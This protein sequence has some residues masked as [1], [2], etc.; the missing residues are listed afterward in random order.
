MQSKKRRRW[1]KWILRFIIGVIVLFLAIL[2]IFDYFV[3]F[4]M[5]DKELH[6]FFKKHSVPAQVR[7][8]QTG[9]RTIRYAAIGNDSLPVLLFIHG[10][11]SSLSIYR[12]YYKDSLFLK[13]FRM[14]AVDRPGYGYSGLGKPEPSIQKQAA[15]IRPILDSLNQAK[16]PVIVMGGSYGT[17][18]ACRL[19]MDYP[20]LVNGLV[21][22]APSL[23]PGA[24]QTFW[25]TYMIEHPA[26]NW[27]IPRMLQS[28]NAEKVHH[29]RQLEAMLP[30]WKNIRVPVA[31]IQGDKDKLIDTANA[32]FARRHLVNAPHLDIR[33]L[34]NEPH[35]IAFTARPVVRQKILHVLQLAKNLH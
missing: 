21:L 1:G 18:I 27:F 15:M 30:Y 22:V 35:F 24:E 20:H 5:S 8:Y 33:F 31:Y 32:G 11:P 13:T 26:L 3:Q 17:S 9:G 34:K 6:S 23:Q 16:K 7:Y 19:A 10:A 12:D 4:R 2:F 25:F 29:R 14:Y 28:A